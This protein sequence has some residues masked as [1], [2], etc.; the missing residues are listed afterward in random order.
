MAFLY[1]APL[2]FLT[3]RYG[4]K[5]VWNAFFL[6]ILGNALI[7][8]VV[9]SG[10]PVRNI[11]NFAAITALFVWIIAPPPGLSEKLAMSTRFVIGSC[12][13]ALLFA[14]IFHRTISSQHFTEHMDSV[15]SAL[16]YAYSSSGSDVVQIAL[17]SD[18]QAETILG[19]FAAVMLRG[20]SLVACVF[21]YAVCRQVGQT[22]ARLF[23]KERG[24]PALIFFHVP[25]RVIWVF[26]VSL[27]LIIFTRTTGLEIPEILLWNVLVICIILYLAQGLGILQFF[28]SR[29]TVTPFMRLAIGVLFIILLFSPVIN[30]LLLGSFIFLGIAENW[31]PF[32]VSKLNGPPSTPE[33]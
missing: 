18:L 15:L 24:T 21:L 13:G 25:F 2:A 29:P 6:V 20:G 1:L 30:I 19:A 26:S 9:V 17:L 31:L 32:R 7:T 3:F 11:L 8:F 14:G 33:A 23:A 10:V 5:A 22:F 27:L 28:L 4:N 16:V 12:L